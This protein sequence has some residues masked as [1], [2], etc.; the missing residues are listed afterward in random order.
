MAHAQ[1]NVAHMAPGDLYP[2]AFDL[3]ERF[4][5]C[6]GVRLAGAQSAEPEVLSQLLHPQEAV[7]CSG[8]K[9]ARRVEWI[10]GR[11]ASRLARTGMPCAQCPTLTDENGA[12]EVAA[13][14]SVSISHTKDLAVALVS[15][16]RNARVGVDVE[17]LDAQRLEEELLSEKIMSAAEQQGRASGLAISPV[18]RLSIKEAV[19]KAVC[20][21]TGT[22]T[23][24]RDI[25]IWRAPDG[26]A[27][28]Q[29]TLS[30]SGIGAEAISVPIE[31]HVLSLARATLL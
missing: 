14:V 27:R 31:G 7:L 24:L 16:G 26:E 9:G 10:G 29:V 4:G 5:R 20:A 28:F 19:F 13:D 11:V 21:L 1:A 23:A 15:A 2:L 3:E 22:R 25:S 30:A 17:S 6:V 18:Q 8:M 12:P